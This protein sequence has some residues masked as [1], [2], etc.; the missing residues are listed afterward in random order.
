M[1]Y[2]R[3]FVLL[4]AVAAG[5]AVLAGPALAAR[6]GA[7]VMPATVGS[8]HFLVHFQSDLVNFPTWA[9]TQ[10][11]AGDVA[12]LAERPY[13]AELADG[14]PAPLGDGGL[15][16]DARTDIY[17]ADLSQ[18]GALALTV[19]DNP[20]GATT[21]AYILLDGTN[22]VTT[23]TQ[24]VVAHELFHTLQ[25][26]TWLPAQLSDYWLLEGSAEWMGYRVDGYNLTFG[27]GSAFG[28]SDMSLDCRDPLGTN[29]CDLVD[30]Y[31][32]NGYSRWPFFEYVI[33]KYGNSFV[34]DVLA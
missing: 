22:R 3:R 1:R 21:S 2:L 24:H 20:G 25:L 26:A 14:Y 28:P 7:G 12:A 34:Q 6:P 8:T 4:V 23:L 11:M 27:G 16:G 30:D 29:M 15:G 17:V 33:E 19:P 13:T 5:S 9:V 10:T 32:N 18:S 31:R